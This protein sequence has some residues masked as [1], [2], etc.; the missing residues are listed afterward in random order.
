MHPVSVEPE[1]NTSSVGIDASPFPVSPRVIYAVNP[2][3]EVVCQLR[4]PPI[5]RVDSEPPAAFQEHIRSQYPVLLPRTDGT[6]ELPAGL[7][8][9]VAE[10]LRS[11]IAARNRRVGYDFISADGVWTAGLTREFLALGT[12]R[13][14]RW[15]AF[16]AQLTRPLE[17]L[18]PLHVF[19]RIEPAAGQRLYM[20]R[21]VPRI[22]PCT[23]SR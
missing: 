16:R 14:E 10:R 15:E 2:L 3:V 20:V 6:Q 17:A 12:S 23:A 11:S 19:G 5:L 8:S 18:L 7:P 21:N 13:Y 4:F 9:Q 22:R 1:K